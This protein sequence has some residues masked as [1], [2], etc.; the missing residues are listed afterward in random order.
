MF[1]SSRYRDSS[2]YENHERAAELE[3]GAA[4]AHRVAEQQG[5][6]P[7]LSGHEHSREESE[8]SSKQF[9]DSNHEAQPTVGHGIAAFGHAEIAE[10]AYELWEARG[11]PHG[12][13][14]DDWYLAATKLRARAESGSAQSKISKSGD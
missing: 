6:Q 1:M 9:R 12:S 2:H 14:E 8:H 7:H 10:L 13:P 11:C 4:H 3:D 5:K